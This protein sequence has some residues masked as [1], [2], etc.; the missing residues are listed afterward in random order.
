MIT[1]CQ[2]TC[3]PGHWPYTARCA[4]EATA[5]RE[6]DGEVLDVCSEHVSIP[7]SIVKALQNKAAYSFGGAEEHPSRFGGAGC[8]HVA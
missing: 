4:V 3:N 1:R 6:V 2:W 7:A 5:Q 8:S